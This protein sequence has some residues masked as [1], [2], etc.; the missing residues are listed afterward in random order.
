MEMLAV[1]LPDAQAGGVAPALEK[2]VTQWGADPIWR[3]GA[4]QGVAPPAARFALAVTAAP[5]PQALLDPTIPD[6]EGDLP[7]GP[8]D[9]TG[10]PL[11]GTPVEQTV[12]IAPH[13]V[14]WDP[15][16]QLWYAD[17]VVDPGTAYTPFIRLALARYQPISAFGSHLSPA[18]STEV[19]QLLPDR[20]AVLTR[21]DPTSLHVGLYG[22]GPQQRRRTVRFAVERLPA[23]A[24]SDLGW[25]P[26]AGATVEELAD[27]ADADRRPTADRTRVATAAHEPLLAEARQ[28]IADR[29]FADLV[30]RKE[31]IDVLR[32][33]VIGEARIVLPGPRPEG[34]RWRLVVIEYEV[35]ST[36]PEHVDPVPP[37][38]R[39]P[40]L[41]V[42]YLETLEL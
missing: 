16:R 41:R 25:E 11:P 6:R 23:D 17:I 4:V 24:G 39:D 3:G 34:E 30:V 35:R 27:E 32:P 37:P 21:S 5:I 12:D 22:H 18:V 8:L 40:R 7:A 33:P 28:L 2:H 1:V 9:V 26:L 29:R 14:R 36:D 38:E 31:L 13:L 15:V 20:L 42:V 10:L 19:V